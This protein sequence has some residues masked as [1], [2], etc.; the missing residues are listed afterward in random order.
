L[1]FGSIAQ[2]EKLGSQ[3]QHRVSS[4]N[5]QANVIPMVTNPPR[6]MLLPISTHKDR[7]TVSFFEH[8]FASL[9]IYDGREDSEHVRSKPYTL[10]QL[11][12]KSLSKFL[13]L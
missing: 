1:L 6:F 12:L 11:L 5:E 9:A 3:S 13:T 4:S 8:E 2:I 10:P 7:N